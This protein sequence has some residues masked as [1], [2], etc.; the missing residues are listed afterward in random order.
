MYPWI[1]RPSG[2]LTPAQDELKL[3]NKLRQKEALILREA[4][5]RAEKDWCNSF[6]GTYADHLEPAAND[7]AC[8]SLWRAFIKQMYKDALAPRSVFTSTS[9][10]AC[11]HAIQW[12]LSGARMV[13]VPYDDSTIEKPHTKTLVVNDFK[14]VCALAGYHHDNVKEDFLRHYRKIQARIDRGRDAWRTLEAE[15][16]K[17]DQKR[18]FDFNLSKDS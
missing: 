16:L 6:K 15:K 13:D 4:K 12:F 8:R 7:Y 3:S 14:E 9:I 10:V 17:K 18:R 1:R 2:P 11:D 5:E